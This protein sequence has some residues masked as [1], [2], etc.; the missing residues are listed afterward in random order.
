MKVFSS[1]DDYG[2]EDER[3]YSILMNEDEI[4]LFSEIQKEFNSKAQKALRKAYDL[5]KGLGVKNP[6]SMISTKDDFIS[7]GRVMNRSMPRS[8]HMINNAR[9][10]VNASINRKASTFGSDAVKRRLPNNKNVS[11]SGEGFYNKQHGNQ[12]NYDH[13]RPVESYK[14]IVNQTYGI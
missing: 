14:D 6:G 13:S 10:R 11:H 9:D 2:Y 5:K 8:G 4:A 3:L 12:Y 1:F 7:L